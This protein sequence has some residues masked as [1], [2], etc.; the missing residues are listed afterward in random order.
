LV[1][2]L[3]GSGCVLGEGELD[4]AGNATFDGECADGERFESDACDDVYCGGPRAEIGSGGGTF[5]TVE[6]GDVLPLH[7]GANGGAGGYHL[8]L[9]VQTERLCPILW[10][11]PRIEAEIDGAMTTIYEQRL[12]VLAVRPDDA[13]SEQSY[14]GIRAPLPCALWPDDPGRDASCGVFQSRYGHIEDTAVRISVTAEDHSG[15]AAHDERWIEPECC[16]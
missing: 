7:F 3:A 15:R 4:M 13:S 16:G 1:A 10:L 14:W 11:E 5:E 2:I 6:D 9:S 8:F 12:H